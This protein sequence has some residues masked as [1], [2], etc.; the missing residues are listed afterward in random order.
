MN[1]FCCVYSKLSI[2][3]IL[4]PL[5][6]VAKETIYLP[7]SLTLSEAKQLVQEK[8]TTNDVEFAFDIHEV[9]LQSNER[10]QVDLAY[11]YPR[12]I[13]FLKNLFNMPLLTQLGALFWQWI[14]DITGIN[15][16]KS[17][18]TSEQL[19][20]I[21]EEAG[22]YE[23]SDFIVR[24]SNAQVVDKKMMGLIQK[25]KDLGY[26]RRVASNIGKTVYDKLKLLLDE[27]GENI[28]ALFDK[29]THGN[30]GKVVDYAHSQASK[31]SDQY[32][33][34]YITSYNP[35]HKKLIIFIDDKKK[36]VRAAVRN[37]FVGIHFSDAQHLEKDLQEL[38][39][40][41]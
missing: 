40:F 3:V 4:L 28:F 23:L 38:G 27:R 16:K 6:S 13:L 24:L 1:I 18:A 19:V 41:S 35:E 15:D 20:V 8:K 7:H 9:L 14:I 21:F 36:N 29:D 22:Q 12:K 34:E 11:R 30:E 10:E 17:E 25:L 2:I 32:F 39:I 26:P 5:F 33:Q 37:G 31:P